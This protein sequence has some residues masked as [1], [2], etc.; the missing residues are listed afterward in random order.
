MN[1]CTAKNGVSAAQ[2]LASQLAGLKS[3]LQTLA[4][5][6]ISKATADKI[7]ML[8]FE[9]GSLQVAPV[10]ERALDELNA[11]PMKRVDRDQLDVPHGVVVL[12]RVAAEETQRTEYGKLITRFMKAHPGIT[13]EPSDR[14][15]GDGDRFSIEGT[16]AARLAFQADARWPK[17]QKALV[18]IYM[19]EHLPGYEKDRPKR[20]IR[21][22]TKF[23]FG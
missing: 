6:P 8:L 20:R 23:V 9:L 13:V 1:V 16:K 17:L 4:A 3:S 2:D 14:P 11:V 12:F 18:D 15:W 7:A 10:A 19:A 21:D 22:T 5:A